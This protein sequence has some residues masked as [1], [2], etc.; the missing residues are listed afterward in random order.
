MLDPNEAQRIVNDAR[1]E[2]DR[3]HRHNLAVI[4]RMAEPFK[5]YAQQKDLAEQ[6]IKVRE[7]CENLER[8]HCNTNA[9][10]T[11]SLGLSWLYTRRKK[12]WKL[13]LPYQ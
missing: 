8:E 10:R 13:L 1:S 6:L 5:K 7:H 3:S 12:L 9:M 4:D 11:T 2:I